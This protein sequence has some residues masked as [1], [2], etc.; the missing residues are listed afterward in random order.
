MHARQE[1]SASEIEDLV[2]TLNELMALDLDTIAAYEAAIERI[3]DPDAR[4]QLVALEHDH[5]R[6]VD[7]LTACVSMLGGQPRCMGDAKMLLTQARV[8][9][10]NLAGSRRVL[11]AMRANEYTAAKRYDRAVNDWIGRATHRVQAALQRGLDAARDH[12]KLLEQAV[13]HMR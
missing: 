3:D 11:E 2:E 13:R 10:A 1:M 5:H 9:L 8:V 4:S 6:Q 7:E 12:L